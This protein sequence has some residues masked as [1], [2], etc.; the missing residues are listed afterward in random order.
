MILKLNRQL[1]SEFYEL[2]C[3]RYFLISQ[4]EEILQL[5]EIN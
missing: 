2:S 3:R 1:I 4:L 5:Q